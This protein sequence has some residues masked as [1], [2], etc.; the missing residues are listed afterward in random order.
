MMTDHLQEAIKPKNDTRK[1]HN[2]DRQNAALQDCYTSEKK[3]VKT[4]IRENKIEQYRNKFNKNKGNIAKTWKAI[5]KIIPNCR[6]N[7]SGCNFD[8][9]I[10]KA[11]EF[12]K[13]SAD[14]GRKT[15][16]KALETLHGEKVMHFNDT[17]VTSDG[18]DFRPQP[19]DTDTIIRTI[20]VLKV[21]AQ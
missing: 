6:S 19:V 18:D 20:K 11:N 5:R 9:E 17:S 4:Q 8:N 7:A 13:H 16:E 15:H 12:N 21:Q 10:N 3:Q 1:K 2:L 14:V